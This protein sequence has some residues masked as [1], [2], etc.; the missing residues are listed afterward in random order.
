MSLAIAL[1]LLAATLWVGGMFFAYVALR[2]VAA[3]EL[4]PPARLNLW[5]GVFR[6]FFP[7][8]WL[9]VISL[10]ASGYHMVFAQF[11]GFAGTGVHVHIMHGL[12]LLMVILYSLLYFRPYPRLQQA[13]SAGDFP[14]G[15]AQLAVIRKIILTNL[16]LGVITIIVAGAGRYI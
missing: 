7:W 2:P 3:S 5:V 15:A 12:G 9:F 1:H 10:L 4:E 16:M 14:A 13:V 8:V 6:R 11:G